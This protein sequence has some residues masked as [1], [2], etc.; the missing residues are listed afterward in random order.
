MNHLHLTTAEI[1]PIRLTNSA[2][3]WS[4]DSG[5]FGP[6]SDTA[7]GQCTN[8][9]YTV[10]WHRGLQED[11]D[12]KEYLDRMIETSQLLVKEI[13]LGHHDRVICLTNSGT[14]FLTPAS[15][16]AWRDHKVA[17]DDYK[18][19]NSETVVSKINI[20]YYFLMNQRMRDKSGKRRLLKIYSNQ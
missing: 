1:W 17:E 12:Q 10:L 5:V 15:E 2:D 6:W 3:L 19:Y 18:S 4:A 11:I 8:S 14:A 20:K 16:P 7:K 13:P 9:T